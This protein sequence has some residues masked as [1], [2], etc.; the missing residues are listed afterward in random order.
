MNH[1][2]EKLFLFFWFWLIF[3]AIATSLTI[4][5]RFVH[6]ISPRFRLY[7]LKKQAGETITHQNNPLVAT[8]TRTPR[9]SRS[10]N[11]PTA[12]LLDTDGVLSS[13]SSIQVN[14]VFQNCQVIQ[15]FINFILFNL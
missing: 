3:L 13:F 11:R 7:L 4:V 10:R 1:L 15:F 2:N 9:R 6:L 14:V 5:I 12:M 8:F